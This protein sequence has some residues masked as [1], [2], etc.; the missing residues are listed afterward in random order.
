MIGIFGA[1]RYIGNKNRLRGFI[2]RVLRLRGITGGRALDPFCGTASVARSLKRRGFSVLASDVM[3]YAYVFGRAYV[4]TVARPEPETA[5]A[6]GGTSVR[7][8]RA[9]V[10]TLNSLPPS[11][12]F[13]TEHF[14]PGGA[15]ADVYGRMYF[16][17][18]SAGRIDTIRVWLHQAHAAKA[19]S[20]ETYFVLLAALI[21]AA[22]RVANTTGVYAAFVK[23]WQSNAV[24]PLELRLEP[25]VAGNSCHARQIDALELVQG[26]GR[27]DLLY[28][29]PPYNT[30]Q[31]PGYYHIPELIALGWFEQLPTL[32]GKTGLL[33][34]ADKRSEWCNRG[35]AE[36]ALE[37]LLGHARC[38]HVL[39]S[40]NTEGIIPEATIER[41]FKE[42]GRRRT[43]K[44]YAHSY[45]RYRSDSDHAK[46][47]YQGAA[48][49]EFLYCISR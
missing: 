35:R 25:T 47:K 46:R 28:L 2:G 40:Y 23:S 29:D 6:V 13:I 38:K 4:E 14:S 45:R 43:F 24:R 27:F 42:H 44:R 26:H 9:L 34:D 12:D 18:Q 32:R 3:R 36:T 16:T 39:M 19:I 15:A 7:S 48:V 10:H 37:A 1:V 11:H 21:E 8:L 49:H 31:Y 41:L 17:P 33:P 5:V 22:D 30:R 20:E